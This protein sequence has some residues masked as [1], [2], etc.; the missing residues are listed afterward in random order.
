M[1]VVTVN[2]K[3]AHHH[4]GDLLDEVVQGN[5]VVLENASKHKLVAAL[6]PAKYLAQLQAL[7]E[8]REEEE[9]DES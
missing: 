6:V 8:P 2:L 5:I 1:A 4:L 3:V 7:V 9:P